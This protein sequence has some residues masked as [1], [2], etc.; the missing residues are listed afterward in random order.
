[1]KIIKYLAVASFMLSGLLLSQGVAAEVAIIINPKNPN[2]VTVSEIKRIFLGKLKKFPNGSKAMPINQGNDTTA[3]Q[4]FDRK[5][6][7]KSASQIKSYWAKVV[8]S[9][10]GGPPTEL[11]TAAE[12]IEYVSQNSNGIGYVD[13]SE[14]TDQ[15]VVIATF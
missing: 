12:V 11:S 9:G 7:G 14:L 6:L 15:V 13:T 3:R 10:K 8:F 2:S 4:E 1:M 5:V